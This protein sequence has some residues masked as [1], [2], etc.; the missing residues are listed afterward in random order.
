MQ[1]PD[2]QRPYTWGDQ[3]VAA[4]LLDLHTAFAGPQPEPEYYLGSVVFYRNSQTDAYEIID[5]QQRLTTL[6]VLQYALQGALPAKVNLE[7]RT[8]QSTRNLL[9]AQRCIEARLTVLGLRSITGLLDRLTF[10][11]LVIPTEDAAFTFFDTQNNR[12]LPLAVPDYLKAYHLRAIRP[13]PGLPQAEALQAAYAQA[14]EQLDAAPGAAALLVL[15]ERML[16]RARHW[17]GQQPLAFETRDQLLHAFQPPAAGAASLGTSVGLL[18]GARPDECPLAPGSAAQLPYSMR[19]FS[20]R[21]PLSSGS[22]FFEYARKYAQVFALL[23]GEATGSASLAPLRV[24]WEVVYPVEMSAYLREFMQLCLLLYHDSFGTVELLQA[25][26]CF[27]Y[28]VGG[29]RLLRQ[30]VRRESVTRLLREWPHN[31]LDLIVQAYTPAELF[32]TVYGLEEL[33]EIYAQQAE[34][35]DEQLGRVQYQYRRR[36]LIY[37]GRTRAELLTR[38]LW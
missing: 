11:R 13:T 16:W 36:L 28:W 9:A 27:D 17:R 23:F 5:G 37:F 34:L 31:L 30:Q 6:L 3:Q 25:A 29:L 24:F 22:H 38:E 35:P 26:H 4:L 14:W 20:L 19:A 18:R 15:F 1:I 2:Y 21:Q 32:A 10:T 12:G 7:L 33:R 8:H